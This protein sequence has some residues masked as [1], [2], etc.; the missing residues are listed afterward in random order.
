RLQLCAGAGHLRLA[1]HCSV[2]RP[3][4]DGPFTSTVA[5]SMK[6]ALVF[7]DTNTVGRARRFYRV[8]DLV[9]LISF[10]GTV[11]DGRSAQPIKG[12]ACFLVSGWG[13]HVDGCCRSFLFAD[14]EAG[15]D[16]W[17]LH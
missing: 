12:S 16:R 9:Y 8:K 7:T 1:A 10:E 17:L 6:R 5:D 2:R 4:D 13:N 15:T 3:S 14:P 11:V